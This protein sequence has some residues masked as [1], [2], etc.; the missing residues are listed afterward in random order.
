MMKDLAPAFRR[1]DRISAQIQALHAKQEA[2]FARINKEARRVAKIAI[3]KAGLKRGE[4]L[5]QIGRWDCGIYEGTEIHW[6]SKDRWWRRIHYRSVLKDGR[7][8]K[9]RRIHAGYVAHPGDV[10]ADVKIVGRVTAGKA[11]QA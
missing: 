6:S 11:V 7:P 3:R 8:G 5:I 10:V 2:E 1:V 9:A 4:T